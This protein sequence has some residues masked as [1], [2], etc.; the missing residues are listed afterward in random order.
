[1]AEYLFHFLPKEMNIPVKANTYI[2][3][4]RQQG[5]L[6]EIY[7][8]FQLSLIR[9]AGAITLFDKYLNLN[10]PLPNMMEACQPNQHQQ[11][12]IHTLTHTLWACLSFHICQ[13]SAALRHWRDAVLREADTPFPSFQSE[14]CVSGQA[15]GPCTTSL[16][17]ANTGFVPW[18]GTQEGWES[19]Q[20][21]QL[22]LSH[23]SSQ[24]YD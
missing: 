14:V 4:H 5:I 18:S 2:I 7:V 10:K 23:L 3:D 24:G 1:M 11:L 12:L 6:T 20:H 9:Q 16:G 21:N 19:V 17:S 8:S 13:T 22:H 15:P